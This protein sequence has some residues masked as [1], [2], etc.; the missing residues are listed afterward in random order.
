[1][2]QDYNDIPREKEFAERY[3]VNPQGRRPVP[4]RKLRRYDVNRFGQAPE[5]EPEQLPEHWGL[6]IRGDSPTLPPWVLWLAIGLLLWL[7]FRK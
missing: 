4:L 1:M 6:T 5:L 3:R 2:Y 7:L